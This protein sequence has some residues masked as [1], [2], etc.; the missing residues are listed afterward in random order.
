MF[1]VF[2][3]RV[4]Y[5]IR[6]EVLWALLGCSGSRHTEQGTGSGDDFPFT[7]WLPSPLATVTECTA[8]S[9][10]RRQSSDTLEPPSSGITYR[11]TQ[12]LQNTQCLQ[13]QEEVQQ[14]VAKKAVDKRL[15]NPGLL[16]SLSAHVE[17]KG[18][19]VNLPA[20]GREVCVA[21]L[22]SDIFP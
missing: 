18:P 17:G 22:D 15:I 12:N 4:R 16:G 2:P 3:L 21:A 20:Q 8:L 19:R 13:W 6:N 5:S 11:N 1:Y 9:L 10:V 14:I 7:T